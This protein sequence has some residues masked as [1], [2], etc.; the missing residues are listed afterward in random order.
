MMKD[1]IKN[2]KYNI[3]SENAIKLRN[4]LANENIA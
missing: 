4:L 2:E 1:L 3:I